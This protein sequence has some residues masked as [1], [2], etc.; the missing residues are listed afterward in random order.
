MKN[1]KIDLIRK[2]LDMLDIKM[3]NLVKKRSVLVNKILRQKTYKKQIIDY[4]LRI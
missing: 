4:K 3:L 2:K 1:K